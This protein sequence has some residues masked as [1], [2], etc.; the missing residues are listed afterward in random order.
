MTFSSCLYS[1]ILMPLQLLFEVVYDYAYRIVGHPGFAIVGLSLAINFL[2]LPL[3][4]RADFKQEE[5]R[6]TEAKLHDGVE[7]IRKTFR[8][9]ERTMMLQTYY[10]Q[11]HYSPLS[12]LHGATSLLL[13]IPFFIAAYRFLSSLALLRGISLGPIADLSKPDGMLVIGSLAI[14]VLPIL[15]TA[16]NVVSSALFSKDYPL[17]T[18]IQLYAMSAVFLVLLYD[19]PSGLVFYWTLNNAFSLVKTIFYKLKNPKKVLMILSSAFG[20]ILIILSVLKLIPVGGKYR[21]VLIFVGAILCVPFL[22]STMRRNTAL[23]KNR[24]EPAPD[25]KL[26]FTG[27]L[28]MVVITGLLIPSS[29][30]KSS[31][32]EFVGITGFVHPI[33][34]IVSSLLIALGTF[35]LWFNVFYWLAAPKGKVVFDYGIWIASGIA[36]VNYLFFST[37]L[38][39]ISANLI[40]DNVPFFPVRHILINLLVMCLVALAVYICFNKIP[41]KAKQA[42]VV[43]LLALFC[44]SAVNVYKINK[45]IAVLKND[46]ELVDSQ[47]PTMTLSKDGQNVVVFMLDRAMGEYIPYI[48]NEKPEL[49]DQFSGFTYY[50]NVISF[51]GHTNFGTPALFGGYEYTPEEINRRSSES[52]QSKQDEALKVMPVLFDSEGFDVAIFD[53]PYAGYQWNPDLSIYDDYPN[54]ETYITKGVFTKDEIKEQQSKSR[55]RNFFCYSLVRTAP[56]VIQE[57]LYDSGNYHQPFNDYGDQIATSSSTAHGIGVQFDNSYSTLQNLPQMTR[58]SSSGNNSFVM[59][60]NETPHEATLLKEPEYEEAVFVDNTEYDKN[61]LDRFTINGRTL[62]VESVREYG[63]YQANMAT[64]I[65]LGRWF[66]Y[67]KKNG[68][69]DNTRI[70]L[71]ADHGCGLQQL[72]S[73]LIDETAYSEYVNERFGDAEFYFPL[74][75]VKDFGSVEYAESNVFMT[76]ADVPALAM[77]G[78]IDNP[79]NPFTGKPINSDE[80]TAHDQL[81]IASDLSDI[82]VNNGNQFMPARWYS[83]HDD[84]WDSSNWALVAEESVLP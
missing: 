71:V 6:K 37:K 81:I 83:V 41:A 20:I 77:E 28:V 1:L 38:G 73:L 24:K 46:A 34:Y 64:M 13:E 10:R 72:E 35:G 65:Q 18:K 74:L 25:R 14:N 47:L 23:E 80:K 16:I 82:N 55:F 27:T 54:I 44:M 63:A 3:Y 11:N 36:L 31:P 9:D 32:Q 62:R 43:L 53:P 29:V 56:V 30:I 69:Y 68:V 5:Q 79:I 58:V 60:D 40:Y 7:H 84:I 59:M 45:S 26:F 17:K 67:L 42:S 4:M 66:D 21:V 15:M 78:L 52:L 61:H 8:G 33:W 19:S 22:I 12:A 39:N 51:G 48:F 70:I 49:K 2:V 75:M 50:S 57:T 76:N